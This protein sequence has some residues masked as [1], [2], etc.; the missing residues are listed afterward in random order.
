[1]GNGAVDEVVGGP[2]GDHITGSTALGGVLIA[3]GG[4]GDDALHANFSDAAQLFG[5]IGNDYLAGSAGDDFLLPGPGVD[6]VYGDVGD[7][8]IVLLDLCEAEPGKVLD[9]GPGTDTLVTPVPL[10]ELEAAGVVVR[11]FE[12]IEQTDNESYLSECW[13][14]PPL[15]PADC[16]TAAHWHVGTTYSGGDRVH[17]NGNSL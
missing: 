17:H 10:A 7:D 8:R 2:D 9:G 12:L 6:Y 5:G 16:S 15:L 14:T 3:F 11:N 1:V 13:L 4:G